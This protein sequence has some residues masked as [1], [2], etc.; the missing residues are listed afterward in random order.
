MEAPSGEVRLTWTWRSRAR[1]I[2]WLDPS[3]SYVWGLF[4]VQVPSEPCGL[5]L[6]PVGIVFIYLAGGI[7]SDSGRGD[8]RAF[9]YLCLIAGLRD[10]IKYKL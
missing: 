5:P 10:Y 9:V 6:R 1:L 2:A 7:V 8:L 4:S 3:P